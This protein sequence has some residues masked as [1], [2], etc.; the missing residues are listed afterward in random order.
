MKAPITKIQILANRSTGHPIFYCHTADRD[1]APELLV[2]MK[3]GKLLIRAEQALFKVKANPQ[4]K[5]RVDAP[6]DSVVGSTPST[7]SAALE[8]PT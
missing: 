7:S 5:N 6:D 2:E 8:V 1:H 4:T 3:G